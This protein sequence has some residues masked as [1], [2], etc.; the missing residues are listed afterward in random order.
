MKRMN[1]FA[2]MTA[3][4][5]PPRPPAP[6]KPTLHP[7]MAQRAGM[8]REASQHLGQ[9]IPGFHALP[10]AQKMGAIQHHVNLRLGKAK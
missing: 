7:V 10:K 3:P 2:G 4:P 8:V 1:R 5:A 6:P 9:A